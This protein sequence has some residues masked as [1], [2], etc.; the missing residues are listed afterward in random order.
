M[1]HRCV[2]FLATIGSIV[3]L[4]DVPRGETGV[5]RG[6]R[7]CPVRYPSVGGVD[8]RGRLLARR[9]IRDRRPLRSPARSCRV[10]ARGTT[11]Q[12]P[13][14]PRLLGLSVLRKPIGKRRIP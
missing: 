1:G 4:G 8:D 5:G 6:D 12:D 3:I 11:D 2:R 10:A 9:S 13:L 7:R 14:G